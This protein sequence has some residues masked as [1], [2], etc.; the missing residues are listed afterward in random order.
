MIIRTS[1]EPGHP[2][3]V[4]EQRP[5]QVTADVDAVIHAAGEPVERP[6]VY[7]MRASSSSVAMPFSVTITG[8]PAR[9]EASRTVCP[10]ASG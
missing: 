2:L 9:S 8:T 3:E 6:R 1:L 5:V 10:S 7:A 4:V